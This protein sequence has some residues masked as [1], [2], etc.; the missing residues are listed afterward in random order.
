MNFN[1]D[2]LSKLSGLE[3]LEEVTTLTE[4]KVVNEETQTA[5]EE[6]QTVNENELLFELT[7]DEDQLTENWLSALTDAANKWVE[8]LDAED[9]AE[10]SAQD[11][12]DADA[13][14]D[15]DTDSVVP[16]AEV[17]LQDRRDGLSMLL[18]G[19][20]YSELNHVV[21]A[22]IDGLLENSSVNETEE[23][24]NEATPLTM[25]TLRETVLELR[26]E[27][28]AEQEAEQQRL[29]EAPVRRAIRNEIKALIAELPTDAATNW[30]YG[31]AG[32]PQASADKSR[33]VTLPGVGF[34]SSKH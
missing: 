9:S 34:K 6:T 25:E 12:T 18:H 22:M 23:R 8:S 21:K 7:D 14:A 15:T 27:I 5:N 31:A 1:A 16:P 26:D 4:S 11:G 24:I 33:A 20:E 2:R 10:D 32:K 17:S 29:A 13:D 28:I 19:K 3:A 30:M